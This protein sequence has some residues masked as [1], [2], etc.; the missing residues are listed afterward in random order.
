MIFRDRQHAGELLRRPLVSLLG[1]E[2]PTADPPIVLGLPRGG[3]VVAA[4]VSHALHAPLD[5]L[6]VRKIGAPWQ[7]ELALGAIAMIGGGSGGAGAS[8]GAV[9]T[10]LNRETIDA[11]GIGEDFIKQEV[12]A[13]TAEARRRSDRFRAS[14]P[15]INVAGRVVVVV[16]DGIATGATVKAALHAIRRQKPR[17]LILAIPVAPPDVVHELRSEVDDLICLSSPDFF[18]SVGGAYRDFAQTSDEEVVSL[19]RTP[20]AA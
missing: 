17:R 3:V 15:P 14:R 2:S 9:E 19:L 7:P 12:E 8:A 20:A 16:D 4:E 1:D 5:V 10:V 6:I 18:S 13:E 11:L